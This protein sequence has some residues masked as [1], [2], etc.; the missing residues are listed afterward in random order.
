MVNGSMIRKIQTKQ[1]FDFVRNFPHGR[2]L[3][4]RFL[5][6]VFFSGFGNSMIRP[7][8]SRNT[9]IRLQ[10]IPFVRTTPMS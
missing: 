6:A 8:I 1:N 7:G 10:M 9:V 4:I 5:C 3:G 2:M